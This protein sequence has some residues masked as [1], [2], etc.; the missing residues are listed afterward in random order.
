MTLVKVVSELSSNLK[1]VFSRLDVIER[2]LR[3]IQDFTNNQGKGL[4]I[5][6]FGVLLSPYNI[7]ILFC[8]NLFII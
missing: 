2:D 8:K 4:L 6:D 3:S 7:P 1:E 5:N